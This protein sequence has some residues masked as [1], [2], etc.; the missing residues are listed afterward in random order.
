MALVAWSECGPDHRRAGLVPARQ[1]RQRHDDA[2]QGVRRRLSLRRRRRH[3]RHRR[4]VRGGR[5][6]EVEEMKGLGARIRKWSRVP[7]RRVEGGE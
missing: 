2:I 3:D 5:R 4:S 1:G 6:I 7:P